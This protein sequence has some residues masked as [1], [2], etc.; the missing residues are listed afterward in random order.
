MEVFKAN[1]YVFIDFIYKSVY[2]G[3]LIFRTSREN[4]RKNVFCLHDSR[5]F[6]LSLQLQA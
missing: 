3:S 6:F 2:D 1:F 4:Q 5:I